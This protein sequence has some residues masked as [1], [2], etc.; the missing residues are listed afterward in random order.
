ML[1]EELRRSYADFVAAARAGRYVPPD[2]GWSA[3]MVL[4]HVIVGDRLIAQAAG[5]VMAG[6]TPAFDNL[7]SQSEP[8]LQ[9]VVAAAGSW[10]GLV[11]E[12]ERAAEELIQVA[13]RMSEEQAARPIA[14]KVVSDGS[15]VFDATAPLA[16]L[17]RVP[18]DMHLR[19][20]LQ[21]LADLSE[22]GAVATSPA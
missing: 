5:Q 20:H 14:S 22:T 4:A 8:L 6:Q 11:A 16:M 9:A 1:T 13:A 19:G 2:H 12:V 21:Q 17:M 3:E 18:I 10:D 15:V 7:A